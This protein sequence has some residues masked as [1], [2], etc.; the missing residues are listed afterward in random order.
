MAN[1]TL[2]HPTPVVRAVAILGNVSVGKTSLFERLCPDGWH[3]VPIPDSTLK[4]DRGVLATGTAAAPRLYRRKCG[5]CGGQGVRLGR[6]VPCPC[7][8]PDEAQR[9]C[10]ALRDGS[11]WSWLGGELRAREEP[12]PATET[13]DAAPTKADAR[14]THV[15]DPPGS[16]ALSAA[17]EDEM[18]A[19]DLVLSG[20]LDAI[21]VVADA[22]NL[23]R[24]LALTLQVAE[25]GLPMV[26]DLNMLDEA[27]AM[28][29]EID[30]SGLARQ[31]GVPI[32]HTVAVENRGIRQLANLLPRA[33][34]L[35]R[36]VHFPGALEPGLERLVSM[37]DNPAVA[38]RG[39]ALLLL[40]GDAR[41]AD[42]IARHL[43]ADT[44]RRARAVVDEVAAS[45][46]TPLDV[47]IADAYHSEAERIADRVT[48]Q[49]PRSPDL[50]V[51]FGT[52]AQRPLSGTLIALGV[53]VAAYYWVGAFGA[54]YV[55]DNLSARLF[56]GLLLPLCQQ[57]VALIPSA[58]VRDAIMDPDFG[59]LP[60]GLFLA[61]GLVL[62]VLFCFY[63]LQALLEDS[64]YLPRLAVLLDRVFRKLGLNGQSLIPLVLGFSCAAMAVI[65]TR[66][67][68]SR[69]ERIIVTL[70]VVGVPCAPLL[71]VMVVILSK[72]PWTAAALVFG[73]I[74][75]RIVVAGLV[76][77]RLLSG[78]HPDLILE[79]P[80]MRIP[81]PRILLAKTWR[82][83]WQFM[84]EAVPVF[85]AASFVVFLFDRAGGLEVAERLG[86]P[87][88][89]DLLGLPDQAVQVFIKTAIRRENGA[90]E[91]S[92]LRAEFTNVQLVVTMLVMTF[93][94]P[95]INTTIVVLKERGLKTATAIL[96]T[97][98]V[99]AF[100]I[101]A[102][103][104]LLL[105]VSG[106]TLT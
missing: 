48:L 100:A 10:P 70:L 35:Q 94:V 93:L 90:T 72:L 12:S 65:T 64:G 76:S 83:T 84:R 78:H 87:V 77:S 27:E 55:V 43:G 99:S 33:R 63:L 74:L 3:T 101:G 5:S 67:L 1:A 6:Q 81:R 39:L 42:W 58:F 16:T 95:C 54:T 41:A 11:F 56:E 47:L 79:I 32:G 7:A 59:L 97:V 23:R 37:V 88:V 8:K 89:N 15:Y 45:F 92:R 44:L 98:V 50:L 105:R 49:S 28:G 57:L 34:Q 85:L 51:R 31:L 73:L 20:L 13:D 71:A 2:P 40:S 96:T 52:L 53:L 66:M 30:E 62:P 80:P 46:T 68:P 103:L 38:P 14:V 91:L 4:V 9:A 25:F 86:R 22:K 24:S 36:P 104:N 60:T 106:I 17:S 69:R 26:L 61:I 21:V 19:R 82:R 102:L 75:L 29:L 18:V